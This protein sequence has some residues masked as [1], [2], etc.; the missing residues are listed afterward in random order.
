MMAAI[1]DADAL[2]DVR[3]VTFSGARTFI[4]LIDKLGFSAE[5]RGLIQ[6]SLA[7]AI[8][9]DKAKQDAGK[10]SCSE[11]TESF[12]PDNIVYHR[13]DL[14]DYDWYKSKNQIATFL[15]VINRREAKVAELGIALPV[16][17][18]ETVEGDLI[19][20]EVDRVNSD[21]LSMDG[22][23]SYFDYGDLPPWD[24]WI[25]LYKSRNDWWNLISWV[26]KDCIDL[27]ESG[28][29]ANAVGAIWWLR[30]FSEE[31]RH[32]R[33]KKRFPWEQSQD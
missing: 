15:S 4:M 20:C 31:Q 21:G 19:S 16:W 3:A 23:D 24:T 1:Q 13:E 18:M 30:D 25:W 8:A 9:W 22:S 26:P 14:F 6:N 17:E 10:R 32:I 12:K 5:E 29:Q 11:R 33:T 2:Q 28:I 7:S 27:V